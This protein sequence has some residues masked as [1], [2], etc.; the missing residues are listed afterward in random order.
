[1][2][3]IMGRF[4][5][6]HG[7]ITQKSSKGN[8]TE[9]RTRTDTELPQPDFESGASTNFATPAHRRNITGFYLICNI[10]YWST[11]FGKVSGL[12]F[13]QIFAPAKSALPPSMAVVSRCAGRIFNWIPTPVFTGVTF[14]R[15]NDGPGWLRHSSASPSHC[16]WRD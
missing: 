14:F 15:W 5:C 9:G 11:T 6:F 1:M 4:R 8:G 12:R 10:L 3:A 7:L 13:W 16:K 2:G